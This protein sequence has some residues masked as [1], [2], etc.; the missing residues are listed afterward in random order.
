MEKIEKVL[1]LYYKDGG[2]NDAPFPSSEGQIEI[3]AFRYNATRMGGAPTITATVMYPICLDD[4]WTDSVYA[5]FNGEKYY[6]KQTP[7][8]SYDNEDSRYKHSIE[9]VSERS[10][11]DDVYFFDVVTDNPQGEDKPV[12]NSSKVTFFGNVYEFVK[13]LNASLKYSKVN[14][15]VVVDESDEIPTEDKLVSFEDQFF[16]NVLQE[17]YNTYE[18]PYYFDGRTIH[19]GYS[20]GDVVIPDLEYGIDNALLSITKTNANHKI[21]NRVTGVGSSDNIPFY[22]PNNS[23]KGE[24][25]AIESDGSQ[26]GVKIIDSETFSNKVELNGVITYTAQEATVTRV[27]D[28]MGNSVSSGANSI[29]TRFTYKGFSTKYEMR[30][31][32]YANG[33]IP[34]TISPILNFYKYK[35]S[36]DTVGER[37]TGKTQIKIFREGDLIAKSD[38]FV[39]SKTF[40]IELPRGNSVLSVHVIFNPEYDSSTN[41]FDGSACLSWATD[42][43]EGW[44]Y[45]EKEVKLKDLGLSISNNSPQSGSTIT[46]KLVKYINTSPNLMPSVY[47]T[48]DGKERF[49]NAIDNIYDGWKFNNPYVEGKPKEHIIKVDDIKPTIK[50]V[51]NSTGLRMDMFSEFAYDDDDND[52]TLPEEDS[53]DRKFLHSYFFGKLRK[54]DFNLFDHA[55]EQQPMTVSFTSGDCGACNFEIGVSDEFPNKNPVLVNADGTLKRDSNGR[56][57]CGQFQKIKESEL[58]DR[59]QDTINNEVWIALKKEEDTYGILMPKAPKFNESGEQIEAGHRPKAAKD[60]DGTPNNDGDTFVIL[61][62]HLPK[63]YIIN[64]E[65]KLEDEIIKYLQENNDEKF[66][67]SINFSRI[68]FAENQDILSSLNENSKVRVIYDNIPYDLYVSSF[69]YSISEG[70]ILPDIKVELDDTLKVSSN[71]IRNAINEVKSSLGNNINEIANAVAMQTRSFV[72]KIEDDN[73]KGVV[74][75][76]K[77]IT[78][79]NGGRVD[80]LDNNSAKLTIDYLEVTKKATFTSLEIQEKTHAGGQIL[81][82]PAAIKCNNVEEL[83]DCYRCYFQTEGEGGDEI[84]NQFVVEDQAICQT[85]NVW[86]SKYYWRLVTG[87]GENYID[88][89]KED[90]DEGSDIPSVGDK[91]IQLGHRS[92]ETR[93]NAIVIA[94][95]GDGSPYIIQYKGINSFELPEEKIATKLS[96]T[97]NIFTGIVHIKEGSDGFGELGDFSEIINESIQGIEVGGQNML[98]NSGF[99]GDY[100][101]AQLADQ[102]VLDAAGEMFNPPLVHWDTTG[103]VEVVDLTGISVSGKG[104][105]ISYGKISQETYNRAIYSETYVVSFKAKSESEGSSLD[106]RFGGVTTKKD[107]TTDWDKYIVLINANTPI[108]EFYIE[109]TGVVTVCDLQLERGTIASSWGNSFL[110]NQSDRAYYQAGVYVQQALH[111]GSTTIGGGLVLTNHVKVGQYANKEMIQETGGMQGSWT[112][113]N[114]VFIWGGGSLEEAEN[115]VEEKGDDEANFVVTH[116]GKAILNDAVVRGTVYAK[117]GSFEGEIKASKG[118]FGDLH[119]VSSERWG[120]AGLEGTKVYDETEAHNLK[121]YPDYFGMEGYDGGKLQESIRISPYWYVDRHDMDGIVQIYTSRERAAINIEGGFV[122]G[123]RMPIVSTSDDVVGLYGYFPNIVILSSPTNNLKSV[124]LPTRATKG[125]TIHIINSYRSALIVGMEDNAKKIVFNTEEGTTDYAGSWND[126]ANN[127]YKVEAYF[128][129]SMWYLCPIR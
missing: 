9:L 95:Y 74:N 100:L 112:N 44:Y 114:D 42:S 2:I 80:I 94:A 118:N 96:S 71:A 51:V 17:I 13:R 4:V 1:Q 5:K 68:Y 117:D 7:T 34:L 123:L 3:G 113:D 120:D 92:D 103:T 53:S 37:A 105:E 89:S 82:T 107:I 6:L 91:I 84:F 38:D 85:F 126:G 87:I 27:T 111:E 31:T 77:G 11:L 30:I 12:S 35:D 90:C 62:I 28:T 69:S 59:Q 14:Y 75:F 64:A 81:V 63:S 70:D 102:T 119:I 88:L 125:D 65:K 60:E 36:D 25:E 18:V 43:K 39:L 45:K 66:T 116:G 16:S 19:I 128:D 52:E 57:I 15:T 73:A 98:R 50:G 54:L 106:V 97:E 61:G 22:Y 109:S 48:T 129:G 40:D 101:S 8:S 93:Q 41:W 78:F 56:V 58:Q 29:T 121:L 76:S 108:N 46:Q 32:S 49:Y 33:S 83:D 86:E 67:F 124:Y 20:K 99:T 10:I 79:E 104:V 110:D 24:I 55:I 72:S 127:P 47:R 115:A 26:L 23:P 122:R 21:V